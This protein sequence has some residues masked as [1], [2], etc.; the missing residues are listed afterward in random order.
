MLGFVVA[1]CI[2][3]TNVTGKAYLM[4]LLSISLIQLSEYTPKKSGFVMV[5]CI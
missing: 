4:P 2:C 3:G 5:R 1:R